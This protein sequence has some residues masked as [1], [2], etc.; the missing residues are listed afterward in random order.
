MTKLQE[1]I[2][3]FTNDNKSL[4]FLFLILLITAQFKE[5]ISVYLNGIGEINISFAIFF[6]VLLGT[7][8]MPTTPLNIGYGLLFGVLKGTIITIIATIIIMLIQ[9]SIRTF[10]KF[11][12]SNPNSLINK[13]RASKLPMEYKILIVRLNPFIPLPV[14]SSLLKG[15]KYIDQIRLLIFAMLGTFP[16]AI[17]LA[18]TGHKIDKLSFS[19]SLLD[20]ILLILFS[21]PTILLS[22]E[23]RN[24]FRKLK[25]KFF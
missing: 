9:N 1:K 16:S 5:S 4:I 8:L 2:F 15:K 22:S 20:F 17:V 21:L 18:S 6:Y 12:K 11:K 13:L 7:I 3:K 24:F 19:D 25:K 23:K 10:L 14:S